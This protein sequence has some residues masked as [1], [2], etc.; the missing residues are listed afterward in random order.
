MASEELVV[1][2][3]SFETWFRLLSLIVYMLISWYLKESLAIILFFVL[4]FKTDSSTWCLW[5]AND[6][7]FRGMWILFFSFIWMHLSFNLVVCLN[8]IKHQLSGDLLC[9]NWKCICLRYLSLLKF[10]LR[11]RLLLTVMGWVNH[12]IHSIEIVVVFVI[13]RVEDAHS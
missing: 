1:N 3:Q 11:W 10:F 13:F 12:H 4:G 7:K 8:S 5:A 2:L 9:S 6:K